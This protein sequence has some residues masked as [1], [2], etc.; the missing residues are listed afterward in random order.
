MLSRTEN[1]GE[2]VPRHPLP[3]SNQEGN[4]ELGNRK[5]GISLWGTH[6]EKTAS[7]Q[8]SGRKA[9][10]NELVSPSEDLLG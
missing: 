9:I 6:R 10:E 8:R 4:D 1:L 5:E 7:G 2:Q 3:V